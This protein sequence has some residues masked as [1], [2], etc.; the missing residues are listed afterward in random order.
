MATYM[1]KFCVPRLGSNGFE[2]IL[3]CVSPEQHADIT[4]RSNPSVSPIKAAFELARDRGR[5]NDNE[6]WS[7]LVLETCRESTGLSDQEIE[8]AASSTTSCNDYFHM[9]M[10]LMT[11]KS[12]EL[13]ADQAT[14]LPALD[15]QD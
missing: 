3:F 13:T 12:A 11:G 6:E 2:S 10:F 9:L 14:E 7:N 1:A 5:F 15:T 8:M 4:D